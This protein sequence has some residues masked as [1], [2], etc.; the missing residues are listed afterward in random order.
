MKPYYNGKDCEHLRAYHAYYPV[1]AA[2]MLWCGVPPNDVQEEL[3]RISPHPN[4]RG[5][6]THPFIS[7]FEVRCRIIH[8]AIESGALP[9][10]RENGK[11]TDDHIAPERRHV[12]REHLKAWI[13]KEHPADKATCTFLFDEIERKTHAA[14]NADTYRA[15]QADR[16]AARAE[17]E[18]AK[19]DAQ[20]L[21]ADA[22]TTG[23]QIT[24]MGKQIDALNA[25]LEA[26]GAP[27]EQS[28]TTYLNI[29]AALLDCIAGN[30]PKSERH[31]SFASEA[32]L[33]EAIDEHYRGYRGLSQSNLTRKFPEAKRSMAA[34]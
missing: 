25:K 11:V 32:K 8:D 33:I 29:I 17:L 18:R 19:A 12:S 30:L 21:R 6:F 22:E 14:I 20:K 10:S 28:K 13:V 4:I 3:N 27:D 7:C 24:A 26:A 15:L 34:Q 1:P 5:V 2:A 9:A 31:P 16:D 23:F